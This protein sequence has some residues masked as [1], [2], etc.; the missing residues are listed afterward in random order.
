MRFCL[1]KK[2]YPASPIAFK[3]CHTPLRSYEVWMRYML[4]KERI[5]SNL[6]KAQVIEAVMASATLHIK[7]DVAGLIT[8]IS[9]WCPSTH[10]AICRWGEMTI[11]LESVA[12]LLSLPVARNLHFELSAEENMMFA[13]LVKKPEE[14]NQ[15]ECDEKYFYTWWVSERFPTRPKAGQV[16][17]DVLSVVAFLS[18]W[19]SR[20]VFD[21]GSGK[22]IIR[23][24]LIMFAIKLAQGVVLPLGSLFLGSLYSHLDSL[25]ADVY[26]SNG[27]MKVESHI[28]ITF[29]QACLWENFK[30]YAHVPAISFPVYMEVPEYF[31]GRMGVQSLG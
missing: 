19:L 18:L 26:V 15:T 12:T 27:Y 30:G 31:V 24:K 9:R 2:E 13:A 8:F 11:S 3:I 6:T 1:Q 4:S 20:D 28:H 7:K 29:L 21:D 14:Y 16:L 10:T 25:A 17:D 22:K 23:E 5:K